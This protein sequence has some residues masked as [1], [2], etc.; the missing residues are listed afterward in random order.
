MHRSAFQL[1]NSTA[2]LKRVRKLTKKKPVDSGFQRLMLGYGDRLDV[3]L[4]L[5]NIAPTTF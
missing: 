5:L 4:M 2:A 1:R 3:N